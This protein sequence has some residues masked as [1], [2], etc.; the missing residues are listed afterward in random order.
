MVTIHGG[1]CDFCYDPDGRTSTLANAFAL[2]GQR[3]VP[4]PDARAEKRTQLVTG[5]KE[6]AARYRPKRGRSSLQAEKR[7][8]LVT[9]VGTSCVSFPP[10]FLLKRSRER[11][12]RKPWKT[13]RLGKA[14]TPTRTVELRCHHPPPGL[15]QPPGESLNGD[16]YRPKGSKPQGLRRLS[17]SASVDCHHPRP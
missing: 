3:L 12:F 15:N 7:T 14:N 10:L 5:R 2:A 13:P 6:D 16:E 4:S 8:Q 1:S 11:P 9:A 17:P